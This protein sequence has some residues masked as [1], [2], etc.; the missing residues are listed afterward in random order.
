MAETH[1]ELEIPARIMQVAFEFFDSGDAHAL[2]KLPL[3]EREILRQA[4]ARGEAKLT[5]GKTTR[6]RKT[7]NY[8]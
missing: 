5:P 6:V 7:L 8:D 3:E 4:L 1:V 2:L